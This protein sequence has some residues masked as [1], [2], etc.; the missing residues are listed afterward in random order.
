[1][2]ARRASWP[3]AAVL[4]VAAIA[5]LGACTP[6]S[7]PSTPGVAASAQTDAP[8]A[9]GAG[10]GSSQVAGSAGSVAV[11]PS[12]LDVLPDDVD[13]VAIEPEAA[14]AESI[15]RDPALTADVEAIAIGIAVD[16]E[17]EGANLAIASVVRLR[18]GVFNDAFFRNW[19]DTYD[20]AACAQA[21]GVVGNAEAEI[22]GRPAFIGSCTG[23]AHTYHVVARDGILVSITA[24]GEKRLGERIIEGI[25]A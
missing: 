3:A 15:S 18:P 10:P 12:L 14:S 7:G 1:M 5:M 24:V 17:S 16:A 8:L 25:R 4:V 6:A 20:E 21:G 2:P 11:D 19:R 22:G 9:S 23:G 13:G